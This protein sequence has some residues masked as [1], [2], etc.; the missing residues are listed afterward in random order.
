MKQK[1]QDDLNE[2]VR[3][4]NQLNLASEDLDKFVQRCKESEAEH[5]NN[6]GPTDQLEY[7]LGMYGKETLKQYLK[8]TCR[9]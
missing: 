6:L 1:H 8:L 7:L 5:I 9:I 4:F 3:L 2:M